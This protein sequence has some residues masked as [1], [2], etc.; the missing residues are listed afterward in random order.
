LV[1]IGATGPMFRALDTNVVDRSCL[2]EVLAE[3]DNRIVFFS[4]FVDVL[5][6]V[7]RNYSVKRVS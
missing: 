4:F 7:G 5:A 6:T 2:G 1:V 3:G